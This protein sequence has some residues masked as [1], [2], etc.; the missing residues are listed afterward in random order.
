MSARPAGLIEEAQVSRVA[1]RLFLMEGREANKVLKVRVLADLLDC[2][3]V[4][5]AQLVLDKHR[6]DNE[7]ASLRR[8][9]RVRL[10]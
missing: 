7:P 2:L 1:D 6:P 4:I 10:L 9:T 8:A 5:Q 3:L